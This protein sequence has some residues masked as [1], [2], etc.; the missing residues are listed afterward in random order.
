MST[1]GIRGIQH[2]LIVAVAVS[3]VGTAFLAG[4]LTTYILF[5]SSAHASVLAMKVDTLG[6]MAILPLLTSSSYVG[7][8]VLVV[9]SLALLTL[10]M[11][12]PLTRQLHSAAEQLD[13]I[14]ASRERIHELSNY[15]QLT[16]LPNW[17]SLYDH[18]NLALDTRSDYH[19]E[20]VALLFLNLDRFKVINESLGH[21]A[22]DQLLIEVARRL[23]F[24]LGEQDILARAAGDEFLVLK[25]VHDREEIESLAGDILDRLH[26]PFAIAGHQLYVAATIGISVSP[27]HGQDT[28]LLLK[29]A[30]TALIKAKAQGRNCY[31]FY[32]PEMSVISQER[33]ALE[34]DLR[35]A[36]SRGELE[37][38]YQAQ[39]P[40]AAGVPGG[41]EALLRWHHPTRGMVPPDQFI[42]LAEESG[43]IN[44]IGDWVLHQACRQAKQWLDSGYPIR[45]S[46][47][48]SSIQLQQENIVELVRDSLR[49]ASL[50]ACYLEL[51]LTESC[52]LKEFERSARSLRK[53]RLLG[54]SLAMD[55]FGTGY[56]SLSYLKLLRLHRL[57]IDR[58]FVTGLP[59]DQGDMAIVSTIVAMARSLGLEVVAEGVETEQQRNSLLQ[60]GCDEYQGFLFSK[61]LSAC[62]FGQRFLQ[63]EQVQLSG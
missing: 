11:I 29:H 35:H 50:P 18:L 9:L 61:P 14:N 27:E 56:S 46:V 20:Q 60:L 48:L 39:V 26:A 44:E 62:E 3:S 19:R 36:I 13:V 1:Q 49:Q 12:R 38:H 47:N 32:S 17:R 53:L 51:E 10:F 4:L 57:K 54:V 25:V 33:F 6:F 28:D 8:L 16:G 58:S 5:F 52:L 7:L 24:C 63:T 23:K 42:P 55:D 15:D 59:A 30:D 34:H 22:G 45:V 31:Q 37:L 2:K 41:V 21:A 43:L 40:F